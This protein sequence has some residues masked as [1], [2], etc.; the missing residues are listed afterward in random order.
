M[1]NKLTIPCATKVRTLDTHNQHIAFIASNDTNNYDTLLLGDSLFESIS[2]CNV[3]KSDIA[4]WLNCSVGGDGVQH[5]LYRMFHAEP[6]LKQVLKD[7]SNFKT[8]VFLIG[9]NNTYNKDNAN[10]IYEGII[11]L[12]DKIKECCNARLIVLAIPPRTHTSLSEKEN[13]KKREIITQNIIT[14]NILLKS[15]ADKNNYEYYD[16]TY[17]FATTVN[18]KFEI[19]HDYYIDD[20]HFND[21]SYEIILNRMNK[22]INNNQ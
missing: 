20:V 11:N 19:I 4:S 13:N 16:V 17:D 1:S 22:I 14:C 21:N 3:D 10:N 12:I 15:N 9:T 18:N 7:F 5:L 2:V 6:C 8:I